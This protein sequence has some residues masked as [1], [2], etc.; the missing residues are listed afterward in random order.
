MSIFRLAAKGEYLCARVDALG[1][2]PRG[3][4][5][6]TQLALPSL[7]STLMGLWPPEGAA[8]SKPLPRRATAF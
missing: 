7:G 3:S 1:V 8:F 5:A 2:Q 4:G 6:G